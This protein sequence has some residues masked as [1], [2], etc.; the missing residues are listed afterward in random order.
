ML[1]LHTL[2]SSPPGLSEE[3]SS[4]SPPPISFAYPSIILAELV[5]MHG[6]HDVI[7]I[8]HALSAGGHAPNRRIIAPTADDVGIEPTSRVRQLHIALTH[9]LIT[10][11][12]I[13]SP[14]DPLLALTA[15]IAVVIEAMMGSAAAGS[16]ALVGGK[17]LEA[18]GGVR[19]GGGFEGAEAEDAGDEGPE[20]GNVGYDDGGGGFAGVPVEVDEGAVAGGEVVVAIEDGA[21]DDEGTEGEDAEEDYFP[22]HEGLVDGWVDGD[23]WIGLLRTF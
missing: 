15:D 20:V 7:L 3:V 19:T 14:G 16:D 8:I 10:P 11:S 9:A 6:F 5:N 12:A 17:G 23:F 18:I 13:S 4:P 1:L 2:I 22:G 21:E